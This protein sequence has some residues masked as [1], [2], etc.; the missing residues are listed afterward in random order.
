MIQKESIK[1]YLLQTLNSPQLVSGGNEIACPCPLCGD[2]RPKFYIGPFKDPVKPIQYNCFICK[3]HGYLTQE[4]LDSLN[5]TKGIDPDVINSNK[6]SGFKMGYGSNNAFYR[7][8]WDYINDNE[9]TQYKLRYVNERLG[10]N[11]TYQDCIDN[12]IILNV[13]DLL[14]ANYITSFTRHPNVVE[15]LNNYFIGF[16]SRANSS[17][18]MRNIIAGSYAESKLDKSLQ[19]KYIN[20]K[21]FNNT[22]DDDYYVLPCNVD[23][24][25]PIKL[26]IA[27]G[28]F[29]VLGIK[30]NL[31]KS[32]DNCVYV[33]GKGKAYQT[34]LYWF[35]SKFIPFNL[36]V[37]FFPDKD[38]DDNMITENLYLYSSFGYKFY[39]HRNT[40]RNEKDFGVPEWKINDFCYKVG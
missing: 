12:K 2:P 15:C 24:R 23:I 7:M 31:I 16:L 30:Y 38:V 34:A 8:H 40:Y 35:V 32:D 28:P 17:L 9:L 14:D 21:I 39:I 5:L 6:S 18:N 20:Y 36:E 19:Q 27:E 37:H 10:L 3:E 22:P 26:Y 11:F 4:F 33:A 29:D 13:K 25:K 1:T